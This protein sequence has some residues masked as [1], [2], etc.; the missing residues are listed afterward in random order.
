MAKSIYEK[1]Y[2][3]LTKFVDVLEDNGIE[4]SE[5]TGDQ[6]VTKDGRIITMFDSE[7]FIEAVEQ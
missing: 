4:I 6:I 7:I 3:N 5:F 1:K 2:A